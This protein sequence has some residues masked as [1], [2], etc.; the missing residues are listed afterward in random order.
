MARQMEDFRNRE[1]SA[2]FLGTG[3]DTVPYYI[4]EEFGFESVEPGSG[5]MIYYAE[6]GRTLSGSISRPVR[7]PYENWAGT[8]GP[9]L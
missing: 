5:F 3:Y 2:L 4:Y 8:I 6:S 9:G 1:G 7:R